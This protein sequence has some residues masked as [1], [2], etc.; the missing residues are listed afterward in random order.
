V[1]PP[2]WRK[3]DFRVNC[4]SLLAQAFGAKNVEWDYF[5][6]NTCRFGH[7][8]HDVDEGYRIE[9]EPSF[10]LRWTIDL[11]IFLGRGYFREKF[12]YF[13]LK[14]FALDKTPTKCIF[15]FD[16]T[17]FF[18]STLLPHLFMGKIKIR[19][20]ILH[21]VPKNYLSFSTSAS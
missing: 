12:F 10:F 13:L 9:Q 21:R 4:D 3:N 6:L 8:R 7:K 14:W 18:I 5:L 11:Y 2:S 17:V 1:A 20:P 16:I 19:Y 15:H